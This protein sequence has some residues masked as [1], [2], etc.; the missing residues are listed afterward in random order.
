MV[1]V[2]KG[3]IGSAVGNVFSGFEDEVAGMF[4]IGFAT[5][6]EVESVV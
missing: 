1:P 4:A 3:E 6:A 2:A 5:D